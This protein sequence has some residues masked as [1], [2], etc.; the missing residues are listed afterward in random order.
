MALRTRRNGR[1]DRLTFGLAAVAVATAGTVIGGEMLR[2]ARRRTRQEPSADTVIETAE[3]ALGAAGLATQDAVTVAA[4]GYEATPRGETI[5]FNMLNGFLAGFALM[6]LS[7]AGIRSGWWPL[8]NVSFGER[9]IHHFVPGILIAFA[10]GGTAIAT[11]N[12]R[13]EET[14]AIPFGLGVGMTFDEAA[15]LLDLRDVYWT[16]EGILSI[17]ISLGVAAV[18]ATAILGLRM[19]RRGEERAEAGGA[20]PPPA[21]DWGADPYGSVPSPLA[22][23]TGRW[24]VPPGISE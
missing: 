4:E 2:L 16:R 23:E 17:Q 1:A 18:L 22:G 9:H 10:T 11:Q 21:A 12:D 6:R 5:L 15:L 19:L 8:G 20:I 24:Q 13:L 3:Q 7:T 14:L